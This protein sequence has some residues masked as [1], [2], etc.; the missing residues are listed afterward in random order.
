MLLLFFKFNLAKST[1]YSVVI[2]AYTMQFWI[3]SEDSLLSHMPAEA[4]FI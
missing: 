3:T 4:Q 2:N 1:V